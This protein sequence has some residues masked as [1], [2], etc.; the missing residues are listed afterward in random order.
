MK[1]KFLA[2][3]SVI[4]MTQNNVSAK[5]KPVFGVSAEF[6]DK[7]MVYVPMG[8]YN[9][10]PPM[11]DFLKDKRETK[12]VSVNP[13]YIF[14]YEVS[15]GFY[16]MFLE[17]VKKT[18]TLLYKKALP[19]TTV[20]RDKFSYCEPYVDYYFR[21]PA[22]ARYPVVGVSYDQCVMFCEW[23]TLKY[24]CDPKRKNKKIKFRLPDKYEWAYAAGFSNEKKHKEEAKNLKKVNMRNERIYPW[25]GPYMQ[26]SQGDVLANFVRFDYGSVIKAEGEYKKDSLFHDKGTIYISLPYN[27]HSDFIDLHSSLFDGA[28][29]TAPVNS[30]WANGLGLYNMAGNVEE[31]VAEKGITKGG[32]W[33][34][35]GFYLRNSSEEY[36]NETNYVSS[37]RGFRFVMEVVE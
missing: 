17:D 7:V 22:Y 14:P 12:T 18:D 34:D 27:Y 36:Y 19:D 4:L 20:W 29:I 24:N 37:S 26:N 28:D 31:Y 32:G 30:Y 21:H 1:S 33:N 6:L 16:L 2:L 11:Y 10:Q 35:P 8:T 9:F 13:F 25:A 3:V 15:N 5:T 23:L